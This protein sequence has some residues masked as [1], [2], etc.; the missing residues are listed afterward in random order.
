MAITLKR[1][2]TDGEKQTVLSQHGRKCFATGHEIPENDS[3]HFDHIHAF[4]RGGLSEI[5]NIAPMCG[6]HNKAKGALPLED[7]RI[8]LRMDEFFSSGDKLTLKHL[9][10]YH[11]DKNDIPG[12]STPVVVKVIE[13]KVRVESPFSKNEY[14]AYTCPTTGWKYFYATLGVELL[15]SDDDDDDKIGLQ[16]KSTFLRF[17][18]AKYRPSLNTQL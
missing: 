5:E 14:V 15:D 1:Q 11:K 12:Y 16:P 2:L 3:V 10:Q 9:L 18:A 8:K 7:F 6:H 4:S 13:D 17:R